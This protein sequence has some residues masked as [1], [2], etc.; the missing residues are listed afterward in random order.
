[1]TNDQI[2]RTAGDVALTLKS[3]VASDQCSDNLS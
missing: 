2:N 3:H 1:M